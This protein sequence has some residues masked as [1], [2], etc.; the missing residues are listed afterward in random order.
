MKNFLLF[1]LFLLLFTAC[2]KVAFQPETEQ[3]NLA[4]FDEF[5]ALFRTKYAMFDQKGVDWVTLSDSVRATI[6]DA[7]TETELGAKMGAMVKRLHDGHTSLKTQDSLYVFDVLAGYPLNFD[8]ARIGDG[9]DLTVVGEGA[10][11]RRIGDVGYLFIESFNSFTDEDVEAALAELA[12]TRGLVIDVRLNGGGDPEVAAELAGR[13]TATAYGA[14][15]ESFKTGPEEN[16]FSPSAI[17]LRPTGGTTYLDKK[18]AILQARPSYSATTTLIYLTDPNP[19]VRT[20]GTRS[21]GGTGSVASGYLS[22]GW[23]WNMSVSDYT[24]AQGR[25]FDDGIEADTPVEDDLTTANDEVIDAA[26]AW[27]QS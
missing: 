18:V 6:S 2:E 26:V 25:K 17:Q 3:S 12:D 1:P 27:I 20:F 4:L 7:T 23:V 10:G 16:A 22:N 13:F 21:G 9:L 15:V 11:Y 5:S 24:D 14:G 8:T 19:N